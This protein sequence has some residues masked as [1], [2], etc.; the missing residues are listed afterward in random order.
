[1]FVSSADPVQLGFVA[2]LG[3]PGGNATGVTLLLDKLASKRLEL[4]KEAA[5]R[6]SRVAFLWN[7]DHVDNEL[8]EAEVAARRLG[9]ELQLLPVRG[10]AEFEPA[11]ASASGRVDALYAVSSRLIVRNIDS[12]VHFAARN[13][14]PVAG[15][16]GAWAQQ[17]ALLSYG[18][19]VEDMVG[20]AAAYVDRILK[21]AKPTDL[22]VQQPAK[23]ELVINVKIAKALGL[24]IL[25][26]LL[27][28]A[29]E[30]IE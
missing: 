27:A 3:R 5:P 29:D 26:T 19:N 12:I 6:I 11:F 25:P 8:H 30:V 22:P 4:L 24:T 10:P 17:G 28:R 1:V 18:P 9:I 13:Q 23:F 16:W 21:G 20:R 2:S 15:G 14:L 7:P